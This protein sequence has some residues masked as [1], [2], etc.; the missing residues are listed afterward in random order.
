MPF[1]PY[2]ST[3]IPLIILKVVRHWCDILLKS[4]IRSY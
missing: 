4:N 3:N 1:I 2:D